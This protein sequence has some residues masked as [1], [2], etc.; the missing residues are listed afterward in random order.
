MEGRPLATLFPMFEA[1][2]WMPQAFAIVIVLGF[3][4]A[5]ILAWAIQITPDGIVLEGNDRRT[6]P[7]QGKVKFATSRDGVR[8][9]YDLAVGRYPI[10]FGEYDHFAEMTKPPPVDIGDDPGDR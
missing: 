1:P 10:T 6:L 8:I 4:V 5:V 9:A 7:E 2:A 3:P